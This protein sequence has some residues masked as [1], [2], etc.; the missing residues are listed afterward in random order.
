VPTARRRFTQ[1]RP[2]HCQYEVFGFGGRDMPGVPQVAG[3]YTLQAA[4]GRVIETVAP[5]LIGTDGHRVVRRISLPTARLEP[6]AYEIL[7]NVQDRLAQRAF[8]GR[9]SFVFE[10]E[11]PPTP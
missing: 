9:E 1:G 10:A 7:F 4:N 6:G 3:G 5:T 11:T 2:L 8:A